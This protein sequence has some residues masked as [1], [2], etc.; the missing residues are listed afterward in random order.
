M[1]LPSY[2]RCLGRPYIKIHAHIQC[3]SIAGEQGGWSWSTCTK[4]TSCYWGACWRQTLAREIGH[5]W[6]YSSAGKSAGGR[7]FWR[8]TRGSMPEMAWGFCLLY[9]RCCNC[10]SSKACSG[11]WSRMGKA[12]PC[13]PGKQLLSV[14]LRFSWHQSALVIFPH[15]WIICICTSA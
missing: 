10:E 12:E 1:V 7:I 9:Q 14:S 6:V 2:L 4:P 3:T 11:I 5:H 15:F 8:Q 13:E